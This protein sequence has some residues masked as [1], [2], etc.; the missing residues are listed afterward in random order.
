MKTF[1]LCL[2]MLLVSICSQA[3]N[4]F[5]SAVGSDLNAGTQLSPFQTI[6]K[7]NALNLVGGDSVFFRRGDTFYG[8][9]VTKVGNST[10]DIYYGAYGTG[11]KP[12]ITGLVTVGSLK[13]LKRGL[14]ESVADVSTLPSCNIVLINN[15]LVNTGRSPNS[16]FYTIS[17]TS[18]NSAL[19]TSSGLG[20]TSLTNG[21]VVIRKRRDLFEKHTIL[22]SGSSSLTYAT[23]SSTTAPIVGYGF[24][25]QNT[26]STLDQFGEYFYNKK[27]RL[28][29]GKTGVV[30][31][32]SNVENLVYA[33]SYNKFQ[34]LSFYGSNGDIATYAGSN[35]SFLNCTFSYAGRSALAQRGAAANVTIS[36][37]SIL[38]TR[39][40]AISHELGVQGS[41][42]T[43]NY[44]AE[45][46]RNASYGDNSLY[47]FESITELGSSTTIQYNK[48]INSGFSAIRI[49]NTNNNDVRYNYIDGYNLLKDYGGGIVS[50]NTLS[51]PVASY[52]NIISQ[53][54]I[55]NGL[56]NASGGGSAV[57]QAYGV[58]LYSN[59]A[60]FMVSNNSISNAYYGIYNYNAPNNTYYGNTIYK[61]NTS[62]VQHKD[63]AGLLMSGGI[64][65]K[66]IYFNLVGNNNA[67]FW[68][69][70]GSNTIASF[71]TSDSNY[72]CSKDLSYIN[73][74]QPSLTS[75]VN[76]T[77]SLTQWKGATL[78]GSKDANSTAPVVTTEE[79]H[80]NNTLTNR[81][82]T[83]STSLRDVKGTVYTDSVIIAPYSSVIL[84][85]PEGSSGPIDTI[86]TPPPP[87]TT[88][89][90]VVNP[91][92]GIFVSALGNDAN[93]GTL[94][95]PYKT[96]NK[97]NSLTLGT[98]DSVYFRRGDVFYGSLTAKANVYYGAYGAGA[99]PKISGFT[100]V[101]SWTSMGG[102]NW[103]STTAVSTLSSATMV[104][105]NGV[106]QANGRFP[107]EGWMNTTAV[108]GNTLTTNYT[109]DND[110]KGAYIVMRKKHWIL[111][112]Q[113]LSSNTTNTATWSQINST[114]YSMNINWGFF[115]RN[116]PATVT[117][118]G[119]WYFNP[120][121]KTLLVNMGA[122]IQSVKVSSVDNNAVVYAN[123]TLENLWLEG[124]NGNG[125]TIMGNNAKIKNCNIWFS[126][127]NAM[128]MTTAL[129]GTKITNDTIMYPNNSGLEF[130]RSGDGTEIIGSVISDPG[131]IPG[132]GNSGDYG[133]IGMH[134]GNSNVII[135]NNTIRRCGGSGI[136]FANRT[137]I[138]IENNLV[139]SIALTKDD[140]GGI[141]TY[142]GNGSTYTPSNNRIIGNIVL[143]P[144]GNAYGTPQGFE[145]PPRQ[146]AYG[147]YLDDSSSNVTVS[148]NTVK[149][150]KTA[151]YLNS[152]YAHTIT[153]NTFINNDA[154]MTMWRNHTGPT[155]YGFTV[156][157]N[158]FYATNSGRSMNVWE[159]IQNSPDVTSIPSWGTWDYNYFMTPTTNAI[160]GSYRGSQESFTVNTWKANAKYGYK[161]THS[162]QLLATSYLFYYNATLSPKSIALSAGVTYKDPKGVTYT[163][164]LTLQ[165]FT[166]VILLKQ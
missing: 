64:I 12:V 106:R 2:S 47:A 112:N 10:A 76:T 128:Q 34:N 150:G 102:G 92:K 130:Y 101:T 85:T 28:Y 37:D 117:R 159:S 142:N 86:I 17:S 9:L 59:A 46:G 72:Y 122:N 55:F 1:F 70:S 67:K 29:L 132:A 51:N 98:G 36:N 166:S 125:I 157:G 161:D 119:E 27:L 48:I 105:V 61:T 45:I 69:A 162:V 108:S 18:N 149:G 107:D 3:T 66:N 114:G 89:L 82:L 14:Y 152:T 16:G 143:N 134:V 84:M 133:Y 148:G 141:Y 88:T 100:D 39:H 26:P 24:F 54:L 127:S 109:I 22:S 160:I 6:S 63:V 23:G 151:L 118:Y 13:N 94:A 139:D 126:G 144:V 32:A 124:S 83:L 74:R 33:N 145:N 156:T 115:F 153:N 62:I 99:Q 49:A 41:V 31:K 110:Y 154:T 104:V 97:I 140:L 53:N 120:S 123:A 35:I 20:K 65:K 43:N 52:S 96:I 40:S 158:I 135:R 30:I 78:Y 79:F 11:V 38:T 75:G 77:Y 44:L 165:P 163:N 129:T 131:R 116:H 138:L 113:L 68:D 21:T 80:F 57:A 19:S 60:N 50:A 91:T 155:P 164:S 137:N 147:I 136:R 71:A 73:V 25:V 56:G 111:E 5:V 121:D 15:S 58:Y 8:T 87:D 90:V 103:K 7:V 4:Y 93:N 146:D 42:I 95:Y 81:K